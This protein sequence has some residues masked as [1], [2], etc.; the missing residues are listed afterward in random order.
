MADGEQEI[1]V[2][3]SGRILDAFRLDKKEIGFLLIIYVLG[4]I[5]RLVPR[6][7]ID[8]HLLTFQGDVWYRVCMGQYIKD[9]WELPE[10][11]IRY[12]PYGYVPMWYPPLSPILLAIG[13]WITGLDIPTICSRVLPFFEALSPLTMYFL[14][15]I[16]YDRIT[17]AVSTLM[18]ALT[19]SFIYFTGI[20]DPQSF[21][22]FLIPVIMTIWVLQA[23]NPSKKKLIITGILLTINFF[24]HLSYFLVLWEMIMI[25]LALFLQG[26]AERRI[27]KDLLLVIGM[28]QLLS[29]PWWLPR[30]L[31]WWWIRVLVTSS[32]LYPIVSH[33]SY[34]G[35]FAWVI[36]AFSL[37]LLAIKNPKRHLFVLLW[38]IPNLIES[39]NEIILS[40][41]GLGRLA[42]ETLAK[43]LEGFR[44]FPFLAQPFSM[45]TAAASVGPLRY[46]KIEDKRLLCFI[47]AVLLFGQGANLYYYRLPLR[48]Q[49]SGLIVEEYEAALWFR[50]N[51]GPRARIAAD[52]YRAQMFAGVCGGKALIGGVF[53]LRNVDYPYIKAPG[54][55]QN[56]LYI[57][58]STNSPLVAYNIAKRYN[59]THIFYSTNM[60]L[61]GNLLSSYKPAYE[62]GVD[63]NKEKF[64]DKS[65]FE[66][67]YRRNATFG[68][69]WIIKVC[70]IPE[71]S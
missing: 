56:D 44:F 67:V 23:R 15:R 28:S 31:Y 41:L 66:I 20:A 13:S 29:F 43:P 2:D 71:D 27:F 18:V 63:I 60:E 6:L 46:R 48:F 8:S 53:P 70:G 30:N 51:T 50:N 45:A 37:L 38:S 11:D 65:F 32:G 14:G 54:R 69:V 49:L 42:W 21:T 26:L 47:I 33:I 10:P 55:V 12:R 34:Y 68:E 62:F 35:M 17:G 3:T 57:L 39:N 5:L 58:Y 4:V 16:L 1:H 9:H 36:G 7:E 24:M 25:S 40:A 19:P 52:Y 22:A 59:L 61:Y 64:E